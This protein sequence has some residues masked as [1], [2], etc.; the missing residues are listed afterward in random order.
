MWF[1]SI[2][3]FSEIFRESKYWNSYILQDPMNSY[4]KGSVEKYKIVDTNTLKLNQ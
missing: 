2:F 4:I 3:L 1:G